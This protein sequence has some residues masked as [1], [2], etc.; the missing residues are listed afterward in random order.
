MFGYLVESTKNILK[1]DNIDLIYVTSAS[2]TIEIPAIVIKNKKCKMI[3]EV[4][5]LERYTYRIGDNKQ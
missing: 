1:I 2:L 5:C 4:R 3:F